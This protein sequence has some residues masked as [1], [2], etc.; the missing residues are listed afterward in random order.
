MAGKDNC[1]VNT[2]Q[3]AVG[4]SFIRITIIYGK[5]FVAGSHMYRMKSKLKQKWQCLNCL[6]LFL[7]PQQVLRVTPLCDATHYWAGHFLH[8]ARRHIFAKKIYFRVA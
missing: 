2:L 3:I 7:F 4:R 8:R 1:T 6:L 5:L